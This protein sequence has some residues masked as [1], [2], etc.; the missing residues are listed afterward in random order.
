MKG[1]TASVIAV[2]VI[3]LAI[4]TAY[5]FTPYPLDAPGTVVVVGV[6]GALVFAVQWA[7]ARVRR[8]KQE[9]EVKHD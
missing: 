6:V 7:I 9:T 3:S 2:F 5:S 4:W 8:K 1:T